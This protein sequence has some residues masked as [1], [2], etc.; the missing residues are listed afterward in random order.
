LNLLETCK[1]KKIASISHNDLDGLGGTILAMHYIQPIAKEFYTIN[2]DKYNLCDQKDLD[3]II[4]YYDIFIFTDFSPV[5]ELYLKIQQAGKLIYIFDHHQSSNVELRNIALE[6]YYYDI[7]RCGTKIFLDEISKCVRI[8]K[9]IWQ[10]VELV[11]IYD[12]YQMKSSLWRDA[13][14]LSNVMWAEVN[15][16]KTIVSTAKYINFIRSILYKFDNFSVFCF[17][18]YEN[19]CMDNAEKKEQANLKEAK[20]NLQIRKDGHGNTYGYFECTSKQSI[21]S[22]YILQEREDLKYIISHVTWGET[23]GIVNP[24][25]SIR[26]VEG[27][28]IDCSVMATLWNCGGHIMAAGIEFKDFSDFEKLRKGEI[29]LI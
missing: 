6:N 12:L 9:V 13:K 25:V 7:T 21:V 11:N 29:H 1:D 28:G 27:R 3:I 5:P 19:K 4:N 20:R 18:D 17:T 2:T 15:Y 8:K 10:T 24:K 16:D 14:G 22:N 26:S 23:E